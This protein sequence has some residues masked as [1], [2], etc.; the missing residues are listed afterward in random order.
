[1]DTPAGEYPFD[2]DALGLHVLEPKS[3]QGQSGHDQSS[4]DASARPAAGL[5]DLN[6]RAGVRN[7]FSQTAIVGLRYAPAL[8]S[9]P[10][11]TMLGSFAKPGPNQLGSSA[12]TAIGPWLVSGGASRQ[13]VSQLV[14]TH[15]P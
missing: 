15:G 4:G 9:G 3:H 1:M 8:T 13:T 5:T 11:S 12:L 10:A 7:H 2:R 14:Q 6:R